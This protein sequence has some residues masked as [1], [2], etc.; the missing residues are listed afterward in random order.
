MVKWKMM[1]VEDEDDDL[2]S[3]VWNVPTIEDDVN[4]DEFMTESKM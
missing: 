4:I 3:D 1:R 2:E